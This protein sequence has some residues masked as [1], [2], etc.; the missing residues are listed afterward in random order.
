MVVSV[1]NFLAG[2]FGGGV[3]RSRTISAVEFREGVF[4][5][6]TVNRGRRSPNNGRLRVSGLSGDFEK[7]NEA[8]DVGGD[9]GLRVAHG[10]ANAGLGGEM[11]DVSEW[12]EV[13][14][15]FEERGVVD[16]AVDDEDGVFG[17]ERLAGAFERWVVVRVEVVETE[18]A[19][20]AF[21]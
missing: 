13:E 16:V 20:A 19:V 8:G 21:F 10:V 4:N 17:E 6:E 7:R 1:G 18:N 3:E 12:S 2:F 5:V 14:E 9:V 15:G 11:E